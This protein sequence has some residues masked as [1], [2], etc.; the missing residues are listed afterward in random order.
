M[1]SS[2]FVGLKLMDN[3]N[4]LLFC[5]QFEVAAM[6]TATDGASDGGGG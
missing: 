1:K 3:E 2:E 5:W 4:Y 6:S